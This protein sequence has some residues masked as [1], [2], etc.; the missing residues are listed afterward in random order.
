MSLKPI[1]VAVALSAGALTALPAAAAQNGG[2]DQARPLPLRAQI[3]F[4][5]VDVNGDGAV[6]Q[7]EIVAFQK[8]VFTAIDVDGDGKLT[9][10][11]F[12]RMTAEPRAR[13]AN[14]IG[15]GGPQQGDH[16]PR[17]HRGPRDGRGGPDGRPDGRQGQLEMPGAPMPQ[18]D[19]MPMPQMGPQMG[20][21]EMVPPDG[22]Q[23]PQAFASLDT[24][25]DGVVSSEEFASGA[26]RLPFLPQ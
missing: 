2:D 21:G 8:A 20:E 25:G 14:F 16:G 24:N 22:T 23:E 26:A 19:G 1:L 12:R 4:N 5:L 13:V 17:F 9:A 11:E 18:M 15:R 7:T 6:D 3:L 10:E